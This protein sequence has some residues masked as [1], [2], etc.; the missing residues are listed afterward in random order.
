MVRLSFIFAAFGVSSAP[1]LPVLLSPEKTLSVVKPFD[2]CW[3]SDL[4]AKINQF[5][6]F[7]FSDDWAVLEIKSA[8]NKALLDE[9]SPCSAC[10]SPLVVS[11]GIFLVIVNGLSGASDASKGMFQYAGTCL[12]N[13][14]DRASF[15]N[16]CQR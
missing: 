9:D 15:C 5:D 11:N 1:E 3:A 12:G 2:W 14:F 4:A 13:T 8:I 7:A 6:T 10:P 16:Q